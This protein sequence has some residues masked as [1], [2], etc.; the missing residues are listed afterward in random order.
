[1]WWFPV[2]VT[3]FWLNEILLK[4]ELFPPDHLTHTP[5]ECAHPDAPKPLAGKK[6]AG[7]FFLLLNRKYFVLVIRRRRCTRDLVPAT[8]NITAQS[9]L[10]MAHYTL[11]IAHACRRAFGEAARTQKYTRHCCADILNLGCV[12][13]HKR[14]RCR[15]ATRRAKLF[16]S[17][18]A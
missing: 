15:L 18:S 16:K 17:V 9:T 7:S 11:H 14:P 8:C 12:E 13:K 1:M 10:C 6:I 2:Q 5:R 3:P 4:G